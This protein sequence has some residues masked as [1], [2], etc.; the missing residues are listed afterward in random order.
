MQVNCVAYLEI[1]TPFVGYKQSGIG[2]DLGEYAL[3]T[4]VFFLPLWAECSTECGHRYTQVKS[5]HVNI[6]LKL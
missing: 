2:T 3:D 4:F 6:G 5:V 1:S